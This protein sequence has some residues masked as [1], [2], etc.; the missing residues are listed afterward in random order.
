MKPI[1]I[2]LTGK[3]ALVTGGSSGIGRTIVEKLSQAG[4]RVAVNYI[5]PPQAAL[6]LVEE[7]QKQ[8]GPQSA[9][10]VKADISQPDSVKS[11]FEQIQAA[12]GGLDILVNN[13]GIESMYAA[14]D[15]PIEEWDRILDVNL[16][17]AFLCAQSAA[18]MMRDQ[19][20]GGVVVNISS[21]HDTIARL[22]AVHYCVSKAGLTMLTKTL[23]IEWAAYGIRV[24]AVSPGAIETPERKEI[25][26]GMWRDLFSKW[27]PLGRF[28]Q[29]Q[30]VADVV[31]FLASD[32]AAYITGTTVYI[33]GG[34]AS[35]LVRYD[36]RQDPI[37]FA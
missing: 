27:V 34:Y 23:A 6:A 7:L 10:A 2:D 15:L 17:G 14:I 8:R 37:R 22:G 20:Q 4:A 31:A 36:S 35:N 32:L 19:G 25:I 33:D 24:V 5:D 3:R 13:A 11:L 1:L 18:R 30:E 16:R 9:L 21:M 12:F 29:T 28:G 26:D